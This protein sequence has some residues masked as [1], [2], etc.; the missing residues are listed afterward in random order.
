MNAADR[1]TA[2]VVVNYRTKELTARAV[3]SVLGEDDVREVVIV[4]FVG[5]LG[6][7]DTTVSYHTQLY[8]GR[9]RKMFTVVGRRTAG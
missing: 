7:E 4:D 9:P 1:A 8:K 5:V 2:V 3:A 6:F